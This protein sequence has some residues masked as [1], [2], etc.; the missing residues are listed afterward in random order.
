MLW[1]KVCITILA[2]IAFLVILSSEQKGAPKFFEALFTVIIPVVMWLYPTSSPPLPPENTPTPTEIT[3]TTVQ[4]PIQ[5][6]TQIHTESPLVETPYV[7][8]KDYTDF[9][10]LEPFTTDGNDWDDITKPLKSNVGDTYTRGFKVGQDGQQ[11]REYLL[12]GEYHTFS[13]EIALID[14][15]K[16]LKYPVS[17]EIFGDGESLYTLTDFQQGSFPES[18]SIDVTGVNILKI[19]TYCG[20][21]YSGATT[22]F[23]NIVLE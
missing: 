15:Y 3:T 2:V 21:Y 7:N 10:S 1:L 19:S 12:R 9:Y 14:Y 6:P 13:G 5:Q 8:E 18:F 4:T 23:S 20:L 11:S 17:Y 22:I 16:D